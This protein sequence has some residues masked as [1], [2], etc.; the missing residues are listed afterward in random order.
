MLVMFGY[1][2]KIAGAVRRTLDCR[3]GVL[4]NFQ[5]CLMDEPLLDAERYLFT[6]GVLIGKPVAD[7]TNEERTS[8]IDINFLS[9]L[10][11][12]ERIL[13][14][15]KKA[16]IC[17]VGS[18]SGFV[19]SYDRVYA[20]AKAAVHQYVISRR[21]GPDQQLVAIAPGIIEDAGMTLRRT[22]CANLEERRLAHPKGRFLTCKEV[23]SIIIY[24]LYEDRGYLCNT[25][26]RMNGGEHTR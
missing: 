1:G 15:N 11:A 10:H 16:R 5:A 25:V 2:S 3:G 8:D 4:E 6:A 22:D 13:E 17:I 12:C 24:L 14:A 23:A 19:G 18:E 9:V 21:V 20:G 7:M 26:I